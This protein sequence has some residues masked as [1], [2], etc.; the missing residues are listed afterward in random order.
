MIDGAWRRCVRSISSAGAHDSEGAP[1]VEDA[2]RQE[3][4]ASHQKLARQ[5][6]EE[7]DS[8]VFRSKLPQVRY[9]S[10][11]EQNRSDHEADRR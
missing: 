7:R 10:D 4:A 11:S 1:V 3:E 2:S 9:G 5:E 8:V 6:I